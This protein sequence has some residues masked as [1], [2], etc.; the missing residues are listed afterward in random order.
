MRIPSTSKWTAQTST[1]SKMRISVK[2]RSRC[3]KS[4]LECRRNSRSLIRRREGSAVKQPFKLQEL[5]PYS[6]RIEFKRKRSLPLPRSKAVPDFMNI[7]STA[8]FLGCK[9]YSAP[10]RACPE[11]ASTRET[12]LWKRSKNCDRQDFQI[13]PWLIT[14]DS[15]NHSG[16][17]K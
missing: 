16:S 4:S 11:T 6:L 12:S 7:N 15:L 5:M 13:G 14:K 2:S 9:S 1:I 17:M 3:A 10:L 8:T